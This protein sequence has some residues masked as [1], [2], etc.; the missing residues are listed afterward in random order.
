VRLSSAAF[1]HT[2]RGDRHFYSHPP[3]TPRFLFS[4]KLVIL[5]PELRIVPKPAL[6]RGLG[7]LMKRAQPAPSSEEPA[8]PPESLSPGVASLFRGGNG[9]ENNANDALEKQA[10]HKRKRLVRISLFFADA[11]L[12]ALAAVLVI[13]A[14][15]RV[16]F[17]GIAVCVLAV[18][19]GAW[20]SCLALWSD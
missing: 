8:K 11:V 4:T 5:H 13:K 9:E 6:G 17:A 20:L 7:T 14:H 3:G 15:G 10:T 19:L 16:G 18:T 12:F 2:L 1:S